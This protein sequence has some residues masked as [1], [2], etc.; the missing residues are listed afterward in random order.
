MP[1]LGNYHAA[2]S[3]IWHVYWR[4]DAAPGSCFHVKVKGTWSLCFIAY[5]LYYSVCLPVIGSWSAWAILHTAHIDDVL[6]SPNRLARIMHIFSSPLED[7]Y[8]ALMAFGGP[9][10][11]ELL[12]KYWHFL[13]AAEEV[14]RAGV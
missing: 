8:D 9:Q 13:Q 11:M 7:S 1:C 14:V 12:Q 2:G 3:G 5:S 10:G 6:V 4:R